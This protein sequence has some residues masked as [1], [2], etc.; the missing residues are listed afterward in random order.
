[1]YWISTIKYLRIRQ[2]V[3]NTHL[4]FIVGLAASQLCERQ[5]WVCVA[6]VAKH[7]PPSFQSDVKTQSGR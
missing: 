7:T 1:M 4:S 3:Q 2:N 5:S 6:L